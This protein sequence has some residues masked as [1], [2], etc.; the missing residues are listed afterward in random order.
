MTLVLLVRHAAHDLL[1]RRLAGRLPGV[2]LNPAGGQQSRQLAGRLAAQPLDAVYSSPLERARETAEPI[3]AAQG[4]EVRT[5]EAFTEL[6]FGE[7]TGKTFED[8]EGDPRWHRFN[9]AR[10]S[11]RPP[12]GEL[13]LEVQR[14]TLDELALLRERHPDGRV[15]VVSH[16]DTIRAALVHALGMPLD[17]FWRLEVDPASVSALRLDPAS[18]RVSRLND[19]ADPPA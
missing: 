13:M 9:A 14:R 12:G 18:A 15:L 6:D 4:L 16:A 11:A 5:S 7:W 10:S 2:G 3:A 8:L 1:G 17:L 19:T